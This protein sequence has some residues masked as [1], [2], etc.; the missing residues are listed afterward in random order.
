MTRASRRAGRTAFG[1]TVQSYYFYVLA[2]KIG[3]EGGRELEIP[4]RCCLLWLD[5]S[6]VGDDMGSLWVA[7]WGRGGGV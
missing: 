6:G 1:G 7:G 2:P 3:Q 4:V 5:S